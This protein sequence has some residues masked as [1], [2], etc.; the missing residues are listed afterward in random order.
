MWTVILDRSDRQNHYRLR[1]DQFAHLRPRVVL[2][3]IWLSLH[4]NFL[5]NLQ[6]VVEL[7]KTGGQAVVGISASV[8]VITGEDLAKARTDFTKSAGSKLLFQTKGEQP[9][10]VAADMDNPVGALFR[11][12][13]SSYPWNRHL[14]GFVAGHGRWKFRESL[15]RS[16]YC[17]AQAP[18]C[19]EHPRSFCPGRHWFSSADSPCRGAPGARA[20]VAEVCGRTGRGLSK[21]V[22]GS[23][24]GRRGEGLNPDPV[25]RYLPVRTSAAGANDRAMNSEN[26]CPSHDRNQAFHDCARSGDG[27]D[28]RSAAQEDWQ[29]LGIR[30][31]AFG[32][33]RGCR[34]SLLVVWQG[35][36]PHA[37]S[38]LAHVSAGGLRPSRLA[39]GQ[40]GRRCFS[41]RCRNRRQPRDARGSR[42]IALPG[43][44]GA[45]RIETLDAPVLALG[46]R[47]PVNF[48]RNQPDLAKGLHFCLFNN[49]WGTNYVQWFG[50]DMRFR[51]RISV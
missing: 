5:S 37:G 26:V 31:A 13:G 7:L 17:V 16:L 1:L 36:E 39:A 38:S 32:A 51:F 25:A 50:E 10:V 14:C 21:F 44:E 27:R 28:L 19:R 23:T 46:E 47:M 42:W 33:I 20:K 6:V 41:V 35:G 2:I 40:I 24:D 45:L 8:D 43:P 15:P 34:Y 29:G 22:A 9:G 4:S 3:E 49:G 18:S 48:T 11:R 30:A 12:S